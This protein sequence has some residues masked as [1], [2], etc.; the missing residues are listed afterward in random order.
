M[1]TA[2]SS[3]DRLSVRTL[4]TSLLFRFNYLFA[5]RSATL[6]NR[7][8]NFAVFD[9]VLISDFNFHL[10]FDLAFDL[11]FHLAFHLAFDL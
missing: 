4:R 7:A 6:S 8:L 10:A 1:I 5:C 3:T 9:F 2:N 11:A